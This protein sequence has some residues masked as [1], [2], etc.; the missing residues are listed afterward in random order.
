MLNPRDGRALAL[1]AGNLAADGQT[2]RAAE[3]TRRSLE[4]YPDDMSTLINAACTYAK[5]GNKE[6]SLALLERAIRRNWG[7]RDWLDHDPDF[8]LL[9]DDPRFIDLMSKLK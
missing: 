2:E 7:N 6:K 9:R 5:T 4:L 1:G 3:W 8:D